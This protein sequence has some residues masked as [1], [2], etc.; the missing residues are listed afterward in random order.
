MASC[1]PSHK[2]KDS[3]HGDLLK[4]G[5]DRSTPVLLFEASED[6]LVRRLSARTTC[7]ACQTPYM[8]R[9][10]GTPCPK[11]DGGTLVRRKDDEPEAIRTRLKVYHEQTEP[12]ISW[13]E[14]HQHAH[15][16]RGRHRPIG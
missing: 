8:G 11:T 6:E 2:P 10:P 13:Y 12:V 4:L 5:R 16:P 9:D 14:Q 15:P 7:D 3:R 1:G